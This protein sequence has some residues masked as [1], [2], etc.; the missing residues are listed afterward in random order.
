MITAL[1]Y[2]LMLNGTFVKY[3]LSTIQSYCPLDCD[4]QFHYIS[5]N[6]QIALYDVCPICPLDDTISDKLLC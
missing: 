3:Q 5:C 1:F 4:E 6:A 2:I